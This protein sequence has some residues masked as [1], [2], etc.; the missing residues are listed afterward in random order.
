MFSQVDVFLNDKLVTASSNM[1]PYRAMIE[2]LL[3]YGQGAKTTW[4]SNSLFY[5]DTSE[6]IADALV[7]GK[8]NM[9]LFTRWMITKNSSIIELMCKPHADLFM[10][11]R[12][13]IPNM[14]IRIRMTRCSPEFSI[15]SDEADPNQYM[16]KIHAATL[17]VRYIEPSVHIML[18]HNKALEGGA[19]CKYPLH[20]C[21]VSTYCIPK[22][23][24]SNLRSVAIVGQLPVRLIIGIVRNDAY[25]GQY[26]LNPMDFSPY[27]L[28][29]LSIVI[30]GR[31]LMASPLSPDFNEAGGNMQYTQAY[32]TLFSGTDTLFHNFGSNISKADYKKGYTLY[33][34]KLSEDFGDDYFGMKKE[35]NV[36]VN[37]KF[38]K[39]TE[40]TLNVILYQEYLNILD[41]DKNRLVSFDYNA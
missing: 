31:S 38:S 29:Q 16:I 28:S 27:H 10:Q 21:E 1:Y 23:V 5:H 36:Q 8:T 14:D 15:M 35:G 11:S 22:G 34:F 33:A 26:N 6:G 2:I 4:L 9:G 17:I 37:I 3:N 7:G 12:P 19:T 39:A 30:N 40:Y 25:N 41:I 32:N 18:S 20:R 24:M 13:I